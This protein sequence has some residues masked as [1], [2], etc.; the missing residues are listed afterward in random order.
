MA[1]LFFEWYDTILYNMRHEHLSKSKNFG[2]KSEFHSI[3]FKIH[4]GDQDRTASSEGGGK[5]SAD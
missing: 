5:I 4:L 1:K 2:A 3:F